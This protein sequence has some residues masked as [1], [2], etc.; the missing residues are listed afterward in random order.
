MKTILVFK[1]SVM[2]MEDVVRLSPSL[3]R[4]INPFGRWNFDLEDCD[5]IF[6]VETESPDVLTIAK[7]FRNQ[8]FLCEELH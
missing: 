7:L 6:R 8:G 2:N 5:N 3:N 1:T 4:L